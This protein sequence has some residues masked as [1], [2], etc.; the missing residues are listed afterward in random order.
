LNA[1]NPIEGKHGLLNIF[2]A[3]V[4]DHNR[5]VHKLGSKWICEGTAIKPYHACRLTHGAI[6]IAG[7][8]RRDQKGRSVW[9]IQLDISPL[10]NNIVGLRLPNKVHPRNIVDA[11]F[12]TYFQTAVTWLDGNESGWTVYDRLLDSDVSEMAEKISIKPDDQLSD[13]QTRMTIIYRDGTMQSKFCEAPL[14]E[15]SNPINPRKK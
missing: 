11:Q 7:S 1:S 10:S 12:S 3:R 4:S 2:G 6:D 15:P 5:I 14:G 13:L 8:L 9:S